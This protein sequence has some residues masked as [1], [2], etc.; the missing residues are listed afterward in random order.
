MVKI[1]SPKTTRKKKN[2]LAE[3]SSNVIFFFPP[4][5][6]AWLCVRGAVLQQRQVLP[7]AAVGPP[8]PG[9]RPLPAAGEPARARAAP[10]PRLGA[11]QQAAARH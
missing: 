1:V 10:Q 6:F 11:L 7:T 3:S 4:L 2:N 9:L 8:Q 5:G